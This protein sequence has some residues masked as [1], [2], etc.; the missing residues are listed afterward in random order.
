MHEVS[1]FTS[2]LVDSCHLINWHVVL[3]DAHPQSSI[4]TKIFSPPWHEFPRQ[5]H[6]SANET[7]TKV[8]IFS[9]HACVPIILSA[10]FIAQCFAGIVSVHIQSSCNSPTTERSYATVFHIH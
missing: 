8:L 3:T 5:T 9:L 6:P 7:W 10:L 2:S 1:Y 4:P